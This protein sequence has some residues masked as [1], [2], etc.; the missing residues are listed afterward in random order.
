[1][2]WTHEDPLGEE[3]GGWISHRRKKYM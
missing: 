2:H 1:V 3:D